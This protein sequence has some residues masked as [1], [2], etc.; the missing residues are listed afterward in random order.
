MSDESQP[1]PA[2][3]ETRAP[4]RAAHHVLSATPRAIL[5]ILILAGVAI[6]FSNVVGRH[7]FGTALFWAEEVLVFVVIWSVFVGIVAVTY[8]GAHLRM[9]LLSAK[10]PGVWRKIVNALVW[11]TLLLCAGFV[12]SQ[13]YLV[14]STLG[15]NAIVSN[16]ASVPMVIPH[17]ALFVG[18]IL[19]VVATIVRIRAYLSG[20]F[21]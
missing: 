11:L 16:A 14:I 9:D 1:H 17:T 13:S 10:I 20:D 6:N 2:Q 15:K 8:N 12:A 3:S 21:D 18:F 4:W 19:V 7:L 5:G